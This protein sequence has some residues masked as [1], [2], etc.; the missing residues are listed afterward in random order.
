MSIEVVFAFA[1]KKKKKKKNLKVLEQNGKLNLKAVQ[2][3]RA[4]TSEPDCLAQILHFS[5]AV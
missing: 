3:L 2:Q 5:F 4:N 1:R